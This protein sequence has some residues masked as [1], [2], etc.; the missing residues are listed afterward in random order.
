MQENAVSVQETVN[1][2]M[3]TILREDINVLGAGRTD[4]GVH[5]K[6]FFAHFDII[7]FIPKKDLSGTVY[8]LN[9]FLPDDIVIHKIYAVK[10]D[11][12]ARFSALSRTYEYHITTNKNPFLNDFAYYFYGEL[13]VK[14]MNRGA[15]LL[16]DYIDFSSFSK[17]KTQ[18][19]TNNCK[20][21]MAKWD[22][23]DNRIVFTITADRFLRNMVRAIVGTLLELGQ[24]KIDAK[25]LDIIIKSKNRSNAGFSVP[26]QGLF[27]CHIEYPK[28]IYI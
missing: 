16:F 7:R 27:L 18:V 15:E 12:H 22:N 1:L 5:A 26:A 19:K 2:A 25:E 11:A 20:I 24:M 23:I 14:L 8:K 6:N 21:I 10:N 13:D 17:S 28:D 9:K 4:T 3:K